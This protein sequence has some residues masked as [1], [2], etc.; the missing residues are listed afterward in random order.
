MIR[1]SDRPA[2]IQR[3]G[4][5]T[6]VRA[7]Y[8]DGCHGSLGGVI[9]SCFLSPAPTGRVRP[10]RILVL[11][12]SR[13]P[14]MT[15]PRGATSRGRQ[16]RSITVRGLSRDGGGSRWPSDS[17]GAVGGGAGA[18]AGVRVFARAPVARGAGLGRGRRLGIGRR[19]R[20]VRKAE[21]HRPRRRRRLRPHERRRHGGHPGPTSPSAAVLTR[22]EPRSGSNASSTSS[23]ARPTN[24]SPPKPSKSY[25]T[26]G[27]GRGNSW[28][29]STPSTA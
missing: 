13:M 25:T 16:A 2:G 23:R 15:P 10:L 21:E 12:G 24:S 4:L 26:P 19:R 3:S 17:G 20:L 6:P 29:R 8:S 22:P 27:R 11:S 14:L 9:P 18:V 28:R 1:K 5:I 7:W